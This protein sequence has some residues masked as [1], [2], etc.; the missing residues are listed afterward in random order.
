M[1]ENGSMFPNWWKVGRRA[2]F[3]VC[4]G[5]VEAFDAWMEGLQRQSLARHLDKHTGWRLVRAGEAGNTPHPTPTL[6]RGQALSPR[7]RGGRRR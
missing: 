7:G 2:S 5:D 4:V 3:V 6:A 1:T